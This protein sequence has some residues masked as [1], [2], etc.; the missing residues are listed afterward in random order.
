MNQLVT[1]L[2]GDDSTDFGKL[3]ADKLAQHG[4][5]VKNAPKDGMELLHRIKQ[6]TPQVVI[7][8][9]YMKNLDAIAVMEQLSREDLQKPII[10]VTSAYDN[11]FTQNEVMRL[12]AAYFVLKPFDLNVLARRIAELTGR[13]DTGAVNH[14]GQAD[15]L[16]GKITHILHQ[17]GI[18]AHIK[19]YHYIREGITL[20]VTDPHALDSIT[21]ILYPTIAKKFSTTASRVERAIRH[22]IEVAWD[23][24]DVDVL[25]AYFGYTIHNLR[26]KPTNSEFIAM[27][28]DN[29]SLQSRH[30]NRLG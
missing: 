16:T 12:G 7:M 25:N 3:C 2:I 23:R 29:L 21:K 13:G 22:A 14:P 6:E 20:A 10:I 9:A 15:D 5:S 8:D 28:A 19:G 30:A 27:I 17:I 26:G 18:P 11:A 24:G 1:I 4:F